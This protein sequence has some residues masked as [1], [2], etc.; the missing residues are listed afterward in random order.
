MR[1]G[2]LA[3]KACAKFF[4]QFIFRVFGMQKKP[5]KKSLQKRKAKAPAKKS[6]VKKQPGKTIRSDQDRLKFITSK[7][8][9]DQRSTVDG[10]I[11]AYCEKKVISS[12]AIPSY[13]HVPLKDIANLLG[14]S[15]RYISTLVDQGMPKNADGSYP[16]AECI[17]WRFDGTDKKNLRD[18]KTAV[19]IEI[20]KNKLADL[21][22]KTVSVELHEA[23]LTSREIAHKNYWMQ[24]VL[25][26]L[27]QLELKSKEDLKPIMMELLVEAHKVYRDGG[28]TVSDG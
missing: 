26:N 3:K 21:E 20:L 5:A 22:A 19:E 9:P 8:L 23:I 10:I 28:K 17:N 6:P 18:E 12:K 1:W 27:Q 16:L 4:Q 2:G 15:Q 14:V 13:T 7:L 24:T 11:K 25:M